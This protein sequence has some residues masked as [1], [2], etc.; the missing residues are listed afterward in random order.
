MDRQLAAYAVARLDD[1]PAAILDELF[2]CVHFLKL[3]IV[4]R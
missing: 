1:I 2:E 4:R 3:L